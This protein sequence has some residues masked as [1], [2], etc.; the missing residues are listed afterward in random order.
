[1]RKIVFAL[2]F[3]ATPAWADEAPPAPPP[4]PQTPA[5]LFVPIH[6]DTLKDYNNWIIRI[7]STP[8]LW[9]HANGM[10]DM[11]E[12]L[13]TDAEDKEHAHAVEPLAAKPPP[14]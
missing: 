14:P 10:L 2:I 7:K 1:M 9:D 11:L 4:A 13:K 3:L 6:I 12:Q 5:E 8:L